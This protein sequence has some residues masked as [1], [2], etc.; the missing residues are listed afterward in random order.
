MS[1]R[2]PDELQARIEEYEAC[3]GYQIRDSMH[4]FGAGYYI[5]TGNYNQLKNALVKA[6]EPQFWPRLWDKRYKYERDQFNTEIAR[7]LLNFATAAKAL[8]DN[9]RNFMK[10]NYSS[11]K[12]RKEYQAR[13]D[14]IF[15]P[16]P[17]I[18]FIHNLRNYMLHKSFFAAELIKCESE[19]GLIY[20]SYVALM[21]DRLRAWENWQ[22]ARPYVDA[23][24]DKTDLQEVIRVYW[25]TVMETWK[26]YG[27]Q[28]GKENH[29]ALLEMARLEDRIREVDPS[30]ES[31]YGATY[32]AQNSGS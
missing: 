25:H 13:I 12:F 21:P 30:W 14:Q 22:D 2:T 20:K 17:L 24:D 7:L 11:T 32:T 8:V 26:W 3:V 23:L 6:K 27:P 16:D 28:L 18:Q 10:A 1:D 15:A 4:E 5:F 31:G 9:T 29:E 19:E